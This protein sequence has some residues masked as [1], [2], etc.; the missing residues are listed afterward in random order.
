[1]GQD[2]QVSDSSLLAPSWYRLGMRGPSLTTASP[3]RSARHALAALFT[4]AL[5]AACGGA[6]ASYPDRP[7]VSKAQ[8]TWCEELAKSE[9][10]GPTWE[11]MNTCKGAY[12]SGSAAYIGGMTR[13]FFERVNATQEGGD[14]AVDRS[15]MLGECNDKVMIDLPDTGPGVEEALDARCQRAERCEK[16]AYAECK[17]A[18]KRLEPSQQALF[19]T[20]YNGAALH[21]IAS[22]L[23]SGCGDNEEAAQDA[24]YKAAKDRLLWFP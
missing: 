12:P 3:A 8:S 23:S 13:C 11:H 5:V 1:M 4:A 24:C 18:V 21:E 10:G 19:T 16:V 9:G 2:E 17:A 15:Q 7:D 20:V 14:A 6:G 22:C